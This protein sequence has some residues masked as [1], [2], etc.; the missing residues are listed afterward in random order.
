MQVEKG[1][2]N[3]ISKAI[4]LLVEPV[5]IT[6]PVYI[7]ISGAVTDKTVRR[8]RLTK[9]YCTD[10]QVAKLFLLPVNSALLWKKADV[11]YQVGAKKGLLKLNRLRLCRWCRNYDCILVF[12]E[13]GEEAT[14]KLPYVLDVNVVDADTK[15]PVT[16]EVKINGAAI[17]ASYDAGIYTVTQ[18]QP[19]IRRQKSKVALKW[20]MARPVIKVYRVIDIEMVKERKAETE[21]VRIYGATSIDKYGVLAE[22]Q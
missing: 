4:V 8:L 7:N 22:S 10:G 15:L 1:E 19:D 21:Y 2:N 6:E 13:I 20:Y 9:L 17:Q 12:T 14:V 5:T 18:L 3:V 11:T 16:A